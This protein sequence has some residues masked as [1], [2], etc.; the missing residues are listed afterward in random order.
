MSD[1]QVVDCPH[2]GRHKHGTR[3][4]YDSDKCRC[5]PCTNAKTADAKARR[6]GQYTGKNHRLRGEALL[7]EY[8]HFRS[9]AFTDQEIAERLGIQPESIRQALYRLRRK[10]QTVDPVEEAQRLSLSVPA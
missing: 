2:G 4:G 6:A 8:F 10:D 5:I 7:E 9:F 3:L 1:R